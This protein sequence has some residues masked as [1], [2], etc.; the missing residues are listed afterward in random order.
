VLH[1]YNG[2]RREINL[3]F[4]VNSEEEVSKKIQKSFFLKKKTILKFFTFLHTIFKKSGQV[5]VKQIAKQPPEKKGCLV[6]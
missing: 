6:V 1:I 2:V 3:S 5:V 4:F